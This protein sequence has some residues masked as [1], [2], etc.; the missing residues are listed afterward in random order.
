MESPIWEDRTF[1]SIYQDVEATGPG[2]PPVGGS[3]DFVLELLKQLQNV[4][5]HGIEGALKPQIDAALQLCATSREMHHGKTFGSLSGEPFLEHLTAFM[6]HVRRMTVG[7]TLLTPGFWGACT[8]SLFVLGRTARSEYTLAVCSTG[9]GAEYHPTHPSLLD[10]RVQRAV[11]LYLHPLARERLEDS[12]FWFGLFHCLAQAAERQTTAWPLLYERLLPYAAQRPLSDFFPPR[13][14][15]GEAEQTP[16]ANAPSSPSSPS[17]TVPPHWRVLP[18]STHHRSLITVLEALRAGLTM[19]GACRQ[20]EVEQLEAL[21]TFQLLRRICADLES[22]NKQ[23]LRI[24]RSQRRLIRGAASQLT[25]SLGRALQSHSRPVELPTITLQRMATTAARVFRLLEDQADLV[26]SVTP[27]RLR[28][29]SKAGGGGSNGSSGSSGSGSISN[30]ISISIRIRSISI[31]IIS[32]SSPSAVRP[33]AAAHQQS[34]AL[35]E[36]HVNAPERRDASFANEPIVLEKHE[37][38]GCDWLECKQHVC[39]VARLS[40]RSLE[41]GR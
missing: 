28:G 8:G 38:L 24:P 11:T 23:R 2:L 15:E 12:S 31:R 40:P 34:A 30:S 16:A 7:D 36:A 10:S 32:S 18:A 41:F 13:A 27:P 29:L 39:D 14:D 35:H 26:D 19:S 21:L 4:A 9:D 25:N 33:S 22:S 6:Q 20:S 3:I 17:A 5:E 1:A 37:V